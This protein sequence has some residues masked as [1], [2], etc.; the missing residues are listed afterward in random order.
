MALAVMVTVLSASAH[1]QFDPQPLRMADHSRTAV[2]QPLAPSRSLLESNGITIMQG[3]M[4]L[5]EAYKPPVEE[6][7][8]DVARRLRAE[9]DGLAKAKVHWDGPESEQPGKNEPA[10]A[11]TPQSP[12][13]SEAAMRR[14]G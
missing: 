1:A 14:K 4:L 8:G 11:K 10:E 9:N 5:W 13:A 7:L 12:V 6:P 2:Q 3:E